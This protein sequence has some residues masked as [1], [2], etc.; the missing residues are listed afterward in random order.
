MLRDY[1]QQWNPQ[2]LLRGCPTRPKV[3]ILLR[4]S[5]HL[6]RSLESNDLHWQPLGTSR[7]A[8]LAA[9]YYGHPHAFR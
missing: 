8:F 2:E 9:H 3:P 1:Y 7:I 5:H 6:A 4:G